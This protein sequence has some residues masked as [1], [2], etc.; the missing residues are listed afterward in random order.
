MGM[1]KTSKNE[2]G[3]HNPADENAEFKKDTP[4]LLIKKKRASNE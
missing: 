2:N 1:C 4:N 3:T